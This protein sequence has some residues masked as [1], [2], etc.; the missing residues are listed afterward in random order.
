MSSSIDGG[1]EA[2]QSINTGAVLDIVGASTQQEKN[3]IENFRPPWQMSYAE[4]CSQPIVLYRGMR[5]NRP[6]TNGD[7]GVNWTPYPAATM[8][9]GGSGNLFEAT[10]G[11]TA[12]RDLIVD[13]TVSYFKLSRSPEDVRQLTSG[14]IDEISRLVKEF[15]DKAFPEKFLFPL[16]HKVLA[17][18]KRVIYRPLGVW[19]TGIQT[20]L[21]KGEP[22][23]SEIIE[24]YNK[25]KQL[26]NWSQYEADN[27][28]FDAQ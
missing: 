10:I 8:M 7:Y 16:A 5:L 20:A 27:N 2:S 3:P 23:P 25:V 13:D 18:G 28:Q 6:I 12:L 26:G 9:Y 14:E 17:D 24:E 1:Q 21:R 15:H 22:V 4:L 19:M 11:R